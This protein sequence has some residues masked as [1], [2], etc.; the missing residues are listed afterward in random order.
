MAA[1]SPP[2]GIEFAGTASGSLQPTTLEQT[3][4]TGDE[5]EDGAHAGRVDLGDGGGGGLDG[6][7]A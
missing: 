4:G 5:G 3:E 2:I 6:E 1:S 7:I